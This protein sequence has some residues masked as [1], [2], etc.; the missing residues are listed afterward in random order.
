MQR[1]QIIQ[2]DITKCTTDAIVNAA[3]TTLLGGG[4]Q[5]I[6]PADVCAAFRLR[7]ELSDYRIRTGLQNRCISFDQH[8]RIPFPG[9]A[10]GA[11][12]GWH[13]P[14]IPRRAQRDRMCDNGLL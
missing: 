4:V 2:G 10:R 8:R 7:P 12:R 1:L 14:A 5:I 11:H 13:H 6:E 9:C 3:N